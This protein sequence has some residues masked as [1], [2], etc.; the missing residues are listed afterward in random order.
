M[1]QKENTK[2]DTKEKRKISKKRIWIVLVFIV[3]A[4]IVGYVTYR[5]SYLEILELGEQYLSIFWQNISYQVTTFVIN[6]VILF[7][8]IYWTNKRIKKGLQPFFEEEKKQM[9]KMLNK[10]IA[11]IGAIIISF[12]VTNLMTEKL[13]LCMN[14]AAFEIADPVLGYDISFFIFIQPFMQ[15]MI[16]YLLAVVVGLTIYAAL[17][18]II[19]F[20]YFFGTGIG[21]ETLK[22]SKLKKQI[23][24]NIIVIAFLVAGMIFIETQNVGIQKFLT[25]QDTTSYALWGAGISEVTIKL[26]GYSILSV[27]ILLSVIFAVHY[28]KK[29]QTKKIIISLAVVPSYLIA[30]LIVL[31]GFELLFVNPNELDN[32]QKY[33]QENINFTK[34]AYGID[35]EEVNLAENETVTAQTLEENNTVV[36]N[37]VIAQPDTVLKDLNVLQTNKGYYTYRSTQIASYMIDGNQSLVYISPREITDSV[38]TYQNK[39][40]EYTHGYG[41]IVTSAT[42][43]D[44]KGNLEHLQKGFTPQESDIVSITEPRIYFGLE[45]NDTVVTNNSKT[46]EFDYPIENSTKA[47]NAENTYQGNAGLSLNFMDRL[48]LAIK[49]QDLK[50]AFSGNVD[51]NSKILMNRN[52]IERAKTLMP[53]LLY[54]ENPYL[55]V[56]QEGR[57]IWV[58]DAYTTSSYYP[59]SQRITLEGENLLDKTSISYIRNSVKVLIDAYDGTIQYYIT[60]RNDPIIMTYQ[61]MYK[62]LFVDKDVAI[63]EDISSQFIYPEFLYTIQA[64]IMERYHN[65][66]TDV[67]YRG[68]D[69]WEVATHNTGRVLT[70]SGTPIQPYYTMVKTVD[71]DQAKLGLVLPYTPF[72]KQNLTAYLIGTYENGEPKLTL[73]R[74]PTDSNILGPMQIDT[75]LAQDER[76][77]S[78]IE[79]LNVTGTT[80][81]KNMIVIPINNSLLYVEPIYQEYRNEENSTPILKKVV[82]ASG[83]KVAIGDNLTDALNHLVSQNAVDI[84][85]ENTDDIQGL[86]EAIIKANKNLQESNQ[87]NNWETAGKD[88]ARLQELITSLENMLEEQENQL[89][90]TQLENEVVTNQ[91]T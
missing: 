54:D 21:R 43:V 23:C 66:Q 68:D 18:Y 36:D 55:V 24:T 25:L 9:P 58:L 64:Q 74:Y 6:F 1:D 10:S 62:D 76:I 49:E 42:S 35:I 3:L 32:Q 78:E 30:M 75:Q 73:Y 91:T 71:Q 85:V 84:E 45:T 89:D 44:E 13:M 48:I 63:P 34:L 82:V 11:F 4:L 51:A 8:L 72:E 5:G 83:N 50:L 14:A 57:L 38:G 87:N 79:S 15:F 70:K 12:F 81:T 39:T 86:M 40:Y 19:A 37:I 65:I 33:I 31:V 59:Y 77:A 29:E 26:W 52:I 2:N 61:K 47:E 17:Y 80:I 46:K 53:Y 56:S 69:I 27:I 20:N 41:V 7:I 90:Q 22:Q 16:F 28:F 88:M 67:L 60:D